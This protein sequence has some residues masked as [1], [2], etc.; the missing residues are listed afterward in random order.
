MEVV[1][2]KFEKGDFLKYEN[3]PGSFVIFEG[4]DLLPTYQYTKKFSVAAHYDP[5]KYCENENGV[6]WSTRPFLEIAKSNKPCEKTLDSLEEDYFWKV[7]TETE[8]AAAIQ[9]LR[10]YGYEWDE[11]SLSIVDMET[12]EVVHKIIVPKL[13]YNGDVIKPICDEF[14]ELLT[15]YVIS[16]N[17]YSSSY[18][19]CNTPY[20]YQ[21]RDMYENDYWD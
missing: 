17:T 4:V 7:C 5:S 16:K 2:R 15:D 12:G 13:E 6:G 21:G 14:K 10:D 19:G 18:G 20:G 11:E 8:K 3:K 9:K 1:K